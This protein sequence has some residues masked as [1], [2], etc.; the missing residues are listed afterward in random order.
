MNATNAS[1][2]FASPPVGQQLEDEYVGRYSMTESTEIALLACAAVGAILGLVVV[3]IV[4]VVVT[5]QL[6]RLVAVMRGEEAGVH[7]S[8]L[9]AANT[10]PDAFVVANRPMGMSDCGCGGCGGGGSHPASSS[11]SSASSSDGQ[12]GILKKTKVRTPNL[13]RHEKSSTMTDEHNTSC[14]IAEVDE[15]DDHTL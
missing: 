8:L 3:T 4:L 9:A 5:K 11:S 14:A 10:P 2:G 15:E 6:R 7:T 13:T 12:R 1:L